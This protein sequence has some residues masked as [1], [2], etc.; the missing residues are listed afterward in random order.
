MSDTMCKKQ[1]QK[2]RNS[3]KTGAYTRHRASFPFKGSGF[4]Q[5]PLPF[6]HLGLR[7]KKKKNII[8]IHFFN[9][10]ASNDKTLDGVLIAVGD[11]GRWETLR[12]YPLWHPVMRFILQM[13]TA[14]K[15]DTSAAL[16]SHNFHTYGIFFF[17]FCPGAGCGSNNEMKS[18]RSLHHKE[19]E[20]EETLRK[21]LSF[22]GF[23]FF[24]VIT[25]AQS[26]PF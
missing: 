3:R 1:Q 24:R 16:W 10:A 23:I 12:K 17:F 6:P 2:K 22:S 9:K 18:I 25:F 8:I 4:Q 26:K 21:S 20:G 5:P 13:Y 14:E 11:S 7:K 19:K 15:R